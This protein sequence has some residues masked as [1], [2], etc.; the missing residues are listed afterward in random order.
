MTYILSHRMVYYC[1][2]HLRPFSDTSHFVGLPVY[3]FFVTFSLQCF[4]FSLKFMKLKIRLFLYHTLGLKY[5]TIAVILYLFQ[6]LGFIN[7]S[8]IR[9]FVHTV[10]TQFFHDLQ[11]FMVLISKFNDLNIRYEG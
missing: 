4:K 10:Y 2:N 7:S 6:Y 3:F 8:G 9:G 1:S 5:I 11:F